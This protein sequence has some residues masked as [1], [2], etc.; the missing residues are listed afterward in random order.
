MRKTWDNHHCCRWLLGACALLCVNV[1]V[2]ERHNKICTLD[3]LTLMHDC[4]NDPLHAWPCIRSDV[5]YH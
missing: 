1:Y 4:T 5:F 3:E 2:D